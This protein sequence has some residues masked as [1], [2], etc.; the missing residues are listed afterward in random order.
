MIRFFTSLT[1]KLISWLQSRVSLTLI[2]FI[3]AFLSQSIDLYN[4][5]KASLWNSSSIP[6]QQYYLNFPLSTRTLIYLYCNRRRLQ[7]SDNLLLSTEQTV[8]LNDITCCGVEQSDQ[9]SVE[10]IPRPLPTFTVHLLSHYA[11]IQKFSQKITTTFIWTQ[12][13]CILRYQHWL[14]HIETRRPLW[15]PASHPSSHC[16][17]RCWKTW[18]TA[19]ILLNFCLRRKS[20]C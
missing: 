15:K 5:I 9:A 18:G 13:K 20:L 2:F 11:I 3:Y 12:V 7:S 16:K 8:C 4:L 10:T 1:I 6:N 19:L 17:R 14:I